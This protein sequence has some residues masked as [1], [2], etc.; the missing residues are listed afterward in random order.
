MPRRFGYGPRSHRGD[1][2]PHRYGFVAGE[3]YTRFEPRHLDGQCFPPHGSCPTGSNGE[4]Q[5]TVKTFLGHM[6]KCCIAKISLTNSSTEP[7]TF[8]RPM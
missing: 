5:K 3:S 2:F 1:H 7:S 4:V 8:S 6:V